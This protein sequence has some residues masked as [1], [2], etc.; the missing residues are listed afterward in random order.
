MGLTEIAFRECSAVTRFGYVGCFTISH[1]A[2]GICKRF[3]KCR[4]MRCLLN[5][6][7]VK[8]TGDIESPTPYS[9]FA[10]SKRCA[11]KCLVLRECLPKKRQSA[12]SIRLSLSSTWPQGCC[13]RQSSQDAIARRQY[14]IYAP[15]SKLPR[16]VSICPKAT[17]HAPGVSSPAPLTAFWNHRSAASSCLLR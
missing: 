16:S 4:F 14:S 8:T 12:S 7:F 2:E 11:G 9:H 17:Y 6:M 10:A 1:T 13:M 15:A 5:S 3:V